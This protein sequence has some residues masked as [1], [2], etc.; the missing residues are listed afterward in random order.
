MLS[1][2][3]WLTRLNIIFND[4]ANYVLVIKILK[5][6]THLNVIEKYVTC[7]KAA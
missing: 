5:K 7:I 4:S 6:L 1:G 2:P 3:D